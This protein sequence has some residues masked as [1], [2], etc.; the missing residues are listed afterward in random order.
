M[1]STNED[2]ARLKTK[3]TWSVVVVHEDT[4]AR[5]RAVGFCDQLVTRFW[6]KCEFEVS[7]WPFDMLEEAAS[8]QE[9]AEKAARAD[10]ILF[11]A[12]SQG[13]FSRAVKGW[14]KGWL[15]H[16][17]EREGMLI[18]LMEPVGDASGREG[19]RHR[20]LRDAAHHGAM[21]YLTHFPQD[22]SRSM[23]DSLD[24]YTERA[25]QVTSLLDGILHQQVPPPP[26]LS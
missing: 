17:G 16:R 26:P 19:P 9:A 18:A 25:D 1:T 21:D 20:C 12:A 7:W 8:A 10:L 3:A 13:D 14:I 5:E 2:G 15:D 6:E 11:S 24:S 22:L 4:P 23:P